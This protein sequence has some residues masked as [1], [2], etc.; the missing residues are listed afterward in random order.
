MSEAALPPLREDLSLARGPAADG[1]P[2]WTLYDP[3]RHR[4]IRIGWQDFEILS[5]WALRTPAAIVSALR[6]ETTLRPNEEDVLH[7]ATFARRAGLLRVTTARDTAGLAA[8]QIVAKRS[9][10]SWLMHNYLFLRLRLINPDRFLTAMLPLVRFMF[11]RAY[12]FVLAAMSLLGLFLISR[13]WDTYTHSLIE[14]FTLDGLLWMAV[15]LSITKVVHELGH[16]FAAK[17]YGCRVPAMGVA[18]LVLWPVLW[19]DTTDAWRLVSRRRRLVIDAAGMVAEVNVAAIASIVWAVLPD[20]PARAA[21]FVLSSS[22]WILT[23]F[24]NLSP[25]M[26]FD[27]YYLLSDALDVANL[28]DRAFAFTRWVLREALFRPRAAPPER[29]RPAMAHILVAYALASWIYRF[30]LFTGIALLVYNIA[31]KVLGLVLMAIELW[32][33]VARPILRELGV[34]VRLVTRTRLNIHVVVTGMLLLAACAAL[35][36]PWRGRVDAPALVRSARQATLL[37]NEA[38]RLEAVPTQGQRFAEGQVVFAL[39]SLDIAHA[40]RVAE[41]DLEAAQAV[42]AAREFDAQGRRSR[43]SAF[44]R[45][46]EAAAALVHAQ[47]RAAD[48]QVHA[49]FDGVLTDIPAGLREGA[50][51]RRLEPLGVLIDTAEAVVEAYVNEAD[52]PRVADGAAARFI[53]PDRELP[54][55]RVASIA[56]AST[57]VLQSPELASVNGGPIAVRRDQKGELVP[58]R[59]VYRVL[60]KVDGD[61]PAPRRE[62]GQVA[63]RGP[64]ESIA[65]VLYRRILA[66]LW[67]EASV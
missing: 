30:L 40:V 67:R 57:R 31:F 45:A 36:I 12:L 52:L 42:V 21:A 13:Q 24:V 53:A 51:L 39:T 23:L 25:L 29:F 10:A 15:A 59:A 34:W 22:T 4:F 14:Q 41:A 38:G 46:S 17:R 7:L 28:Q 2:T 50:D 66:V 32:Y 27:G 61:V 49:P 20:G 56:K 44:A 37:T 58:D 62:V 55:L 16:G 63:I 48:L 43:Q 60:L 8:A 5:R 6:Q 11:T 3:A 18:F 64:A 19:T 1:A 65:R 47:A 26:R 54:E 33:F 35:V 9:A